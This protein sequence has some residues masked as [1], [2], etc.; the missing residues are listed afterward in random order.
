MCT[1]QLISHSLEVRLQPA[2]LLSKLDCVH[3]DQSLQLSSVLS[4]YFLCVVTGDLGI[5][6][7]ADR[8]AQLETR[9]DACA[10]MYAQ[11]NTSCPCTPDCGMFA[12]DT[13]GFILQN[14][15]PLVVMSTCMV[16]RSD[17]SRM[18]SI[19]WAL[20]VSFPGVC[21]MN[22]LYTCMHWIGAG[23]LLKCKTFRPRRTSSVTILKKEVIGPNIYS[24]HDVIKGAGVF[25]EVTGDS[26]WVI[27]II[28]RNNE[29]W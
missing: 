20:F 17:T 4:Y 12:F 19:L 1:R 8:W 11:V 9:M 6:S 22:A 27:I 2:F 15:W 28:G 5:W 7:S 23:Q 13:N 26:S 14:V 25:D 29:Y 16:R 18:F 21:T 3:T 24:N 10:C